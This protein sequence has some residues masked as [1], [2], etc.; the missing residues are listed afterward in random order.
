VG[1]WPAKNSVVVAHQGTDP[2][3]FLSLLTDANILLDPLD[4][5]LFPGVPSSVLVHSGFMNA[6]ASTATKI[7]AE[8]KKLISS[9][10][11]TSVTTVGHSL[12]G[13]IATLDALYFKLNLPS[14]IAI[15]S[16]TYGTPRVGNSSFAQFFDSKAS[17]RIIY[18]AP[19]ISHSVLGS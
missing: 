19:L 3:K 12:G 13:A 9:K 6:H 2:T 17:S 10:G 15:K 16:V 7:L 4:P 1:Y 5:A 14:N 8:V 11:A 18:S